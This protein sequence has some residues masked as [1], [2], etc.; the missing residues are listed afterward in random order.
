[1][2]DKVI[3]NIPFGSIASLIVKLVRYGKGGISKEEARDLGED[4]LMMA[5][6]LL[7]KR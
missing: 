6:G 3:A 5:A 7:E 2:N 1:M 4:L